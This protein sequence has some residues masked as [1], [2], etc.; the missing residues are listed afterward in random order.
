ML[1][2]DPANAEARTLVED[3]EAALAVETALKSAREAMKRGDREA[4]LVHVRSGLAVSATDSRL[5]AL[6]REL[7]R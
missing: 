1:Q 7:Q 3:S 6:F 4:A 5:I 2:R